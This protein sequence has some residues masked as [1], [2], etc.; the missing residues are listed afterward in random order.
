MHIDLVS[1]LAPSGG[2]TYLLMSIDRFTGWPEA[3]P[4]LDI[5]AET[6]AKAF[7]ARWDAVFG[8][9]SIITTDRGRQF[10]STLFKMVTELLGT[11]RT[12]T[13][14]YCPAANGF[15]ERFHQLL[16]SSLR[17]QADPYH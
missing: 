7:L 17:A 5:T 1:T 2:N 4:I 8:A 3:I 9:P 10:E 11:K 6:I 16:K 12:R 15:V 13:T 14:S